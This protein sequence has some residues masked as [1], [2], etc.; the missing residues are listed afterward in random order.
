[1]KSSIIKTFWDSLYRL[2]FISIMKNKVENSSNIISEMLKSSVEP[3]NSSVRLH[4]NFVV[5]CQSDNE[6]SMPKFLAHFIQNAMFCFMNQV[7]PT[8]AST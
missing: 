5:L 1:M 7:I 4:E 6:S 2:L 8:S 3:S